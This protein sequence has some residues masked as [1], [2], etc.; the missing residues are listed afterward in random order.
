MQFHFDSYMLA[1]LIPII[2][3]SEGPTGETTCSSSG[4]AQLARGA[5]LTSLSLSML[6]EILRRSKKRRSTWFADATVSTSH[7]R[8]VNNGFDPA[9][10]ELRAMNASS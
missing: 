6:R 9:L 1:A 7:H 5:N 3:P 4:P 2:I 8:L 10:A